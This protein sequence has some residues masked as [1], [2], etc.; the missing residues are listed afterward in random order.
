MASQHTN[1]RKQRGVK[2]LSRLNDL[3]FEKIQEVINGSID[4]L[5]EHELEKR[6]D[7]LLDLAEKMRDE[8]DRSKYLNWAGNLDHKLRTKFPKS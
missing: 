7:F 1:S 8:S 2:P 5:P 4:D 6:R 3:E